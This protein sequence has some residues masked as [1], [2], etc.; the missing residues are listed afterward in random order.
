MARNKIHDALDRLA[1]AEQEF[2]SAEFL[3]P[4][5][6]GGRVAVRVAGVVCHLNVAPRDFEGFGLFRATSHSDATLIRPAQLGERR[7]YLAL[8][9]RVLLVISGKRERDALAVP[10]NEPDA[11]F[12]VQGQAQVRLVDDETQRF[13]TICARFDG[14]NFWFEEADPRSD[15]AAAGYLRESLAQMIDP[16]KLDRSG[17]MPG[18]RIAYLLNYCQRL[19]AMLED[20]RTRDERRIRSALE[21]AGAELRDYAE[22]ADSYR[23]TYEVDGQRHVSVVRKNDLMVQ[24]AGIC[25]SGR[26]NDF[27][28]NSLVG[29][30]R[31][32]RESF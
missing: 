25:L 10:L 19:E 20:A 17:L 13:D 1:K 3:A 22:H 18:Q 26:D 15:P 6:R 27:D 12:H 2:L 29:V 11:R 7:R 31:E 8:F 21:H 16:T 28:L 32:S 4:V 23:V 24:T 14:T 30:L 5:L 9:P